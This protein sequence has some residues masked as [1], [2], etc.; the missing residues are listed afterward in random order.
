MFVVEKSKLK[1]R[2]GIKTK[3]ADESAI[4]FLLFFVRIRGVGMLPDSCLF[5][6]KP[7]GA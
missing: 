7:D 1:N 2:R 6:K 4:Y 5:A 3:Q